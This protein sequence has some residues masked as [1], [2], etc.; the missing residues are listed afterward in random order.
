MTPCRSFLFAPGDNQRL[1]E[2]V[3]DAGADAVVLDLED[4]VSPDRRAEARRQVR[5]ALDGRTGIGVPRIYVRINAVGSTH[6]EPDLEAVVHPALDG[7]R[8]AK[9]ETPNDVRRVAERL[10]SLAHD[11][12]FDSSRISIV[13]T[14]ESAAG[15]LAAAAIAA[16]PRVETV[17]F[18]SADFLRDIQAVADE[19]ESATLLA[20]SMLV[21]AARAAG[22][23]APVASVYTL[24]ADL[25]GLART[26]EAAKRLGFF[27]RSAVH[28]KQVPVINAVFTPSAD[29]LA[30]ARAVAE[31]FDRAA[32]EGASLAMLPSGEM[33]DLPIAA[34]ARALVGLAERFGVR[35]S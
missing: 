5:A 22:R 33:V 4:G 1:L 25:E 32:H 19:A 13:P 6:W 26:T 14:I 28:P 17:C 34:R 2:K 30:R 29:E 15:V 24:V 11:R 3:F 20:R 7:V 18:G 8:L 21:L 12:S 10:D 27:G 31:A 16:A 35:A 23:A 9:V